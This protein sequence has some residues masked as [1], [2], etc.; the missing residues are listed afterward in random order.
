MGDYIFNEIEWPS[1]TLEK[2]FKS[3]YENPELC[4]GEMEDSR[5]RM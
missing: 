3:Q 2:S 4:F 1:S 5:G